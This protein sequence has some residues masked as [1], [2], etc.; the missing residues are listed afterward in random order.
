MANRYTGRQSTSLIIGE[1]QI[2]T[3]MR[4][5]L[6]LI[7]VALIKRQEITGVAEDLEKRETL[8]TVEGAANWCNHYKKQCGDSSKS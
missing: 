1:L 7:K 8:H 4:Y 6:T 3:T 5:H 2:K